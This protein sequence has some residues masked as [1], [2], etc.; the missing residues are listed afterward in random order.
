VGRDLHYVGED[1]L[2]V[3]IRD[4]LQQWYAVRRLDAIQ[5]NAFFFIA[6]FVFA[7]LVVVWR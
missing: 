1:S 4:F 5:D 7:Y 6:G 2:M 3:T